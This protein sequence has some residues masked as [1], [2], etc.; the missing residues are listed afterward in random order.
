MTGALRVP[1]LELGPSAIERERWLSACA[2]VM[3]SG[4]YVLGPE[5]EGLERSVRELVGVP[6]AVGCSSGSDALVVALTA[7]GVG[8]G[9]EVITTSFSFFATAESIVRAGATP[10][11]VDIELDTLAAAPLAV[12]AAITAKTRAI[13][14]V[15]LGG[16]PAKLE[17]LGRLAQARGIALIEDAAQAFGARLGERAVG[18]FGSVGCFSFQATKPLGAL[19]DAGMVV[20]SDAEIAARCRRLVVHGGMGRHQHAEIGG[21]Y[22]LDA[23]QAA[24]LSEKLAMFGEALGARRA[25]AR[26]YDEGLAS[27]AELSLAVER[28]GARSSHALYTVRVAGGK[29]GALARFLFE[30]GIET[31]VYYPA[32]LYRQPALLD[33]GFGLPA[34]SLPFVER[35]CAEVLSLPIYP[36]LAEAQIAHVVRSVR[37]F[38]KP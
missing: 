4:R 21:N 28:T 9:D 18:S 25:V 14:V 15:H 7:L 16:T 36:G 11:F 3:D 34:G 8:R 10:V 22:R 5:V 12:E 20:T 37:E 17:E 2:R 1:F 38:F 19:G 24:I 6:H 35:A 29:R 33:L 27:L 30:R 26:A 13:L 23:L 32:P 31:S